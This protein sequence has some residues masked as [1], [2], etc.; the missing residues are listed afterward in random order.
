M[1]LQGKSFRNE[2]GYPWRK[3]SFPLNPLFFLPQY[4]TL[5]IQEGCDIFLSGSATFIFNIL[6]QFYLLLFITLEMYYQSFCHSSLEN[7][8]SSKLF[9]GH[10]SCLF[11]GKIQTMH[12]NF[13]HGKVNDLLVK[14]FIPINKCG[15]FL[16]LN[17]I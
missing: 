8:Q 3:Q 1:D 16:P 12:S 7:K 10:K 2:K 15:G 17:G 4:S 5:F 6:N 11:R 9:S 13:C 14:Y